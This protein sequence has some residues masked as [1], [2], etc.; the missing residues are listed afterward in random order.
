MAVG[1]IATLVEPDGEIV[2]RV[3]GRLPRGQNIELL[4]IKAS[5]VRLWY[6]EATIVHSWS[7]PVLAVQIDTGLHARQ[8]QVLTNFGYVTWTRRSASCPIG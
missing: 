4:R 6:A 5:D 1:S 7:R 2:Q 3:I 8:G